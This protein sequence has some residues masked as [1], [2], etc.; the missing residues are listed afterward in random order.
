MNTSLQNNR[1]LTYRLWVYQKE[2]FP[3]L[4]HGVLIA[5]FSASA[6]AYSSLCRN[7]IAWVN[8]IDFLC[9]FFICWSFFLL[10]RLFDEFKDE[11][12]DA[13]YRSHLPVPRGLVSLS[14]LRV[15]IY[16]VL[17]LQFVVVLIIQTKLIPIYLLAL[18]YLLLMRVEFFIPGWLKK[19][20]W[21]YVSSHMIIV[22]LIDLYASGVDW[23]LKGFQMHQGLY[24]F[25]LVSFFNGI[26]IEIG[27]KI[28]HPEQEQEG[29]LSY[30]KLY[31][32]KGGT[33]LWIFFLTVTML[34]AVKGSSYIQSPAVVYYLI[35]TVYV[36][37][38]VFGVLFIVYGKKKMAGSIEKI[39]AVWTIGLYT[40]LGVLPLILKI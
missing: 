24:W 35:W 39:S 26:V 34:L 2:R 21:A 12:E 4:G 23:K 19:N 17:L 13:Q 1:S 31:G 25:L 6:M 38:F 33:W 16:V 40:F 10:V 27:R 36:L 7:D 9:G 15:C 8:W 18:S 11:K 37:A 3:I 29:V 28:R 32:R 22:P 14:E 5:V 20:Q 30:T